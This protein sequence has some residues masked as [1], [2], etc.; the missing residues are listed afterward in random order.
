MSRHQ[1]D[2]T[3]HSDGSSPPFHEHAHSHSDEENDRIAI[4]SGHLLDRSDS[5]IYAVVGICFL[6]ASA[7]ALGYTFWQFSVTVFIQLPTLPLVYPPYDSDPHHISQIGMAATAIVD[8]ISGLL[9]VLI[10]VEILGTVIHYLKSHTT[11]LR[12]FLYIGVISA[13]RSI[14]SIGVKLS[15]GAHEDFNQAMIELGVSAAVIVALAITIR[16][17]GRLE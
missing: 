4:I 16:L 6:I 8:L 9:L 14:L 11:S 10:I 13:T 7:L 15:V 3:K 2:P 12:P 17:L 5:I 1:T